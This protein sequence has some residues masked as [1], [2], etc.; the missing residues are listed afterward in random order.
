[1]N[2]KII[3]LAIIVVILVGGL[4]VFALSRTASNQNNATVEIKKVKTEAAKSVEKESANTSTQNSANSVKPKSA[5]RTIR[6]TSPTPEMKTQV[7]PNVMPDEIFDGKKVVKTEAEWRKLLTAAQFYV[8]R[9]K[10]TEKPYT[11]RFTNNKKAGDYHCA[12]CGLALFSSKAKYNSE[13]GWASFF[14]P[15]AAV[16]VEERED[17]S[18]EEAR[19]EIVCARCGSHLGH[20]F[21]DGPE[22]TGLR[23][24]VNSV[25]L[26]F[27]N[28]K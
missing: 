22:P 5:K 12:A 8:L 17:K 27:E 26:K 18:L 19:T 25:A 6:Q 14:Q 21:D 3:F 13:T 16:N 15:I 20:V 2:Y 10:G 24:C 23:Y 9:E 11:G 28:H 4:I 1:M 7:K